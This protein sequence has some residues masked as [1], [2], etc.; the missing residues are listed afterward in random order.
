MQKF[1]KLNPAFLGLAMSMFFSLN[2][3]AA[4]EGWKFENNTWRYYRNSE[5]L[6]SWQKI[7]DKWYFFNSDTSLKTGWLLDGNSWYFLDTTAQNQ[8]AALT[9]WQ[10]IDG[11]CYY[12]EP[13]NPITV[14][15]MYANTVVDG[16]GLSPLGRW[17]DSSGKE[18]FE[19]GKGVLTLNSGIQKSTKH[20][21]G[22]RSTSGSGSS[23]GGRSTSGSGS[24]SG[25]RSTSGRDA[26]SSDS[27][28]KVSGLHSSSLNNTV[29][30]SVVNSSD[31]IAKNDTGYVKNTT[32]DNSSNNTTINNVNTAKASNPATS[33]N[34]TS[35]ASEG[36][37]P[38]T[39][40]ENNTAQINPNPSVNTEQQKNANEQKAEN[41]KNSLITE[42]NNNVVQYT[43]EKGNIRTIIWAKG[44]KAPAMGEGGDFR[45]ELTQAGS[46]TYIDYK[47]PYVFGNSWYDSN[48]T[49]TGGNVDVDKNL[50]FGATASNMLHWWFSQ[51]SDYV[52]S[53]IEKEGDI[54]RANRRLSD[55]KDSFISQQ[56]S[57]IFDLFKV[58]FG[59]NDKGFY[60]D[61]LMDLFINGYAPKTGGG[62]NPERLDLVPDQRGGFFYKVFGGRQLTD[63][64]YGRNYNDL[65]QKLREILGNEGI[66]GLSH[67]TFT[68][69]NHI[70]TLWGAEYDINGKL[71]AVYITD[72][73]DQNED[74]DESSLGMKRF[75]VRN[76]GGVAKVST[77]I[78]NKS[79]GSEIG[80]LHVLYLGSTQWED[81]LNSHQ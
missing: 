77:N 56:N 60:S 22:G 4:T 2:S 67:K 37:N 76:V 41:I 28:S 80:Y 10:W 53:Y 23:G 63:R 78:T 20:T 19:S 42:K 18:I 46:D 8:G 52:D 11:Y 25:G 55:L 6:S 54:T 69:N 43:D 21:G 3:Y 30:K 79:A 68:N 70:V 44:I 49:K 9:G 58:L 31:N 34:A 5:A 38:S 47:A 51:N 45:K 74:P 24:S 48:K 29:N 26:S 12:F 59:Y 15:K 71:S 13:A 17:S 39:K 66:V 36:V 35:T 16:Y 81:Y 33:S 73:D 32:E 61:L 75:E 65:S 64:T 7:N 62:T 40:P 27:T 14:G 1:S 50:C 57:R 72:S